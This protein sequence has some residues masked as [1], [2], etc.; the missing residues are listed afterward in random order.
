MLTCRH[1]I[2]SGDLI[3]ADGEDF[4]LAVADLEAVFLKRQRLQM[5][6]AV[7]AD[8][9]RPAAML[10][11]EIGDFGGERFCGLIVLARD[12]RPYELAR[13]GFVD[14]LELQC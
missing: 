7:K 2:S 1:L 12:R 11:H 3:D 8:L 14:R 10:A 4:A 5:A 13:P 9:L 6:A